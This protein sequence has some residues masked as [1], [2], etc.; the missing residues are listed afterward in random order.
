VLA[1]ISDIHANLEALEAVCAD[2]ERQ[3]AEEIIC[4]GDIVGYGPN[5]KECVDR[6]MRF[7]VCL[8]GNHEE[9]LLVRMQQA[10]FNVKARSSIDWTRAQLDMFADDREANA[11]RWDFLG[12]LKESFRRDDMLF[13]H[14]GPTDPIS[15]YIYPRDIQVPDKLGPVFDMVPHICFVGHTHVPGVWTDDMVYI[16]VR[17]MN[18]RYRFTRKRTIVNVGSVGQPRDGDPRA[19]YVLLDGQS[20]R[21]RRV[22]YP[23]GKTVAKIRAIKDLD[24]FLAERLLEGR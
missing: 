1:V 16:S 22:S 15:E 14:G 20:I 23:V 8:L 18:F 10:V 11:P 21:F 9:A 4:L 17:E 12:S 7:D 5:P 3:G 24:P 19:C 2:I 13:V 6:A